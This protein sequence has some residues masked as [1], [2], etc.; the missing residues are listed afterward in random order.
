MRNAEFWSAC[1]A[2]FPILDAFFTATIRL[3]HLKNT[4][5]KGLVIPHSTFAIPH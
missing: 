4:I 5:P 1:G 2:A 3:R